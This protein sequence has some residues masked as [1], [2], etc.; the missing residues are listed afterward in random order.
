MSMAKPHNLHQPITTYFVATCS[1]AALAIRNNHRISI[2]TISA[3][4][5]RLPN[6]MAS[7]APCSESVRVSSQVAVPQLLN[8]AKRNDDIIRALS[9]AELESDDL[10]VTLPPRQPQRRRRAS[11]RKA[12]LETTTSRRKQAKAATLETAAKKT[13]K[14]SAT[15]GMQ[16]GSM[17]SKRRRPVQASAVVFD[18]LQSVPLTCTLCFRICV[19]PCRFLLT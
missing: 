3:A 12:D 5:P 15:E 1:C 8:D 14:R 7:H 18:A 11:A 16:I 17:S 2:S 9:P 6:I 4:S 10:A 13:R 19:P